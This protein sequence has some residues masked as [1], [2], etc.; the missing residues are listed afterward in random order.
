MVMHFLTREIIA[1]TRKVV[2]KEVSNGDYLG[3]ALKTIGCYWLNWMYSDA[4][5]LYVNFFLLFHMKNL[6][7]RCES[8]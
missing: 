6:D 7:S 5:F 8:S 4:M 2:S 3:R 1:L